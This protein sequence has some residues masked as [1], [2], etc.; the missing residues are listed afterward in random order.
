MLNAFWQRLYLKSQQLELPT[1]D[2]TPL[3]LNQDLAL[4][5]SIDVS[6][7]RWYSSPAKGVKRL[8]LERNG[9]EQSIRTSSIVA[10]APGSL[11]ASHPHPRG[12]EFLVLYG[13]FSDEYGDYPAGTYVRNPPGSAHQPFSTEGCLLLVKLQQFIVTD[14]L[15]VVTSPEVLTDK[16]I[17]EMNQAPLFDDYE[18]V[19]LVTLLPEN[20]IPESWFAEGVEILILSGDLALHEKVYRCGHWLRFP[21]NSTEVLVA[22]SPVTCWVKH[23]HLLKK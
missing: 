8:L 6:E 3:S 9:G 2:L 14:N 21:A 23:R 15:R 18:T 19:A 16:F 11:F 12:E 22:L 20:I 10:Y 1:E 5:A 7:S 13:I 4:P 17:A